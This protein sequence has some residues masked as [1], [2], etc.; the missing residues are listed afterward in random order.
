M[1]AL[2]FEMEFLPLDDVGRRDLFKRVLSKDEGRRFFEEICRWAQV[3]KPAF[4]AACH[5]G[6]IFNDGKKA[7]PLWI[8]RTARGY[9]K[10]GRDE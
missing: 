4:N 8:L 7:V 2:P 1:K 10:K 6:T 9:E 5:D 3:D